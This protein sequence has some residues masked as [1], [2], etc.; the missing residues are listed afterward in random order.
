MTRRPSLSRA[1]GREPAHVPKGGLYE[2]DYATQRASE[3]GAQGAGGS[4]ARSAGGRACPKWKIYNAAKE[5]RAS[6]KDVEEAAVLVA[7]MGKGATIRIEHAVRFV[8]W[9][10]G[11]ESQS[12]A[13]S[14]DHVVEI[15]ERRMADSKIHGWPVA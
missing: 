7:F 6:C 2:C 11:E 9:R 1:E 12:A 4:P 3:T 15:V 14:Y 13:D 10:E 5:Y 8:V